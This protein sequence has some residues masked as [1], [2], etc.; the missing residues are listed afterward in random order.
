MPLSFYI[1]PLISCWMM[2]ILSYERYRTI[3]HPFKKRLT[4][5]KYFA[6]VCIVS[7][8]V[9]SL[10]LDSILRNEVT[11]AVG[12]PGKKCIEIASHYTSIENTLHVISERLLD[13]VFPV[14]FMVYFYNKLKTTLFADSQDKAASPSKRKL[15]NAKSQKRKEDALKTLKYLLIIYV[16]CV[17]PG[18]LFGTIA[19][20]IS[21][22][23]NTIF[24]NY[25]KVLDP[26][27]YFLLFA[28][29]LNNMVN[30]FVFLWMMPD[31]R[32]FVRRPCG[33]YS[34]TFFNSSRTVTLTSTISKRSQSKHHV[35]R[36]RDSQKKLLEKKENVWV[37]MSPKKIDKR[38]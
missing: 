35:N 15:F 26:V 27:Y 24:N 11:P 5:T 9:I 2:V 13:C 7:C 21:I 28:C 31:F 23:N 25:L 16:V 12:T 10:Y 22:Y 38:V 4:K 20:L 29:S 34:R 33:K 17:F 8:L 32:R 1:L 19:Y 3:V 18:R 6:A 36:D 14:L 30:V 37:V